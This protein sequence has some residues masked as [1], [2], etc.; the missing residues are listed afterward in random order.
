MRRIIN[1][2]SSRLPLWGLVFT[3]VAA[4]SWPAAAQQERFSTLILAPDPGEVVPQTTEMISL[5]FADPDR[6]LDVGSVRLLVDQIDRTAEATVNGD[7]LVWVPQIPLRQGVHSI[8]ITM[9][10]MDGSGLPAVSWSFISGAPPEGVSLEAL[11]VREEKRG[12]PSWALLQGNVTFEGMMTNVGGD[13][14]DLQREAPYTG[15]AW[16]NARGRLGGSWRYSANTHLNS[17]ESHIRQPINR[18]RFNLRSNWLTLTVG[19]V[20]PRIHELILWG[21]RVRGWSLDLRGGIVN[22]SVV[23]G[24]SRRAVAAQLYSDDP[25]RVFRRGTF[26]QD[27]FAIRP[28]FG[29]GR[30]LQ[31]GIT[32]MKARDDTTSIQF[33]RTEPDPADSSSST[34]LAVPD[35]KDNLV[36][37][38]DM[39]LKAFRGKLSLSYNN[40]FSLYANDISGG[41]LTKQELDDLMEE[42]GYDPIELPLGLEGPEDLADFFIINESMIPIDPR[43]MTNFA[44]QVRG[45]L[46]IGGHTIGARWRNVGGSYNT[47]G[48]YSLQ[49]DRSG[50]RVQDTFRLLDNR[51]GVTVGWEKYNDN[52]DDTKPAT[53][54]TSA[55]TLDLS[56]RTDMNSPGFA[57][58]Y[59][60]YGRYNDLETAAEG[61]VDEDTGTYS[62]GAFIPVNMIGGLN[63]RLSFNYTSVGREDAL[64]PLTGT[65]NTYYLIGLNNRLEGR[66]T[67]FSVMYG[68]NTSE[69][70]GY[71]AETTF[72]RLL[73]KGRHALTNSLAGTAD[74]TMTT[75]S[76]PESAGDLGLD[77]SKWEM[78]GGAEYYWAPTSFATLRAGFVTYTD[79]R[80]EGVDTS[81]L[82]V[83]LRITQVF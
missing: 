9:R 10:A 53:T 12:L 74:I 39:S 45:T 46:Q 17:Y 18:F 68:L 1:E 83:R 66:P 67:E 58:G 38:L 70:T 13:G 33:L 48:Y 41:P 47:L 20:N 61:G 34:V 49:K 16:L 72:N 82:V 37:G 22:V 27:L 7:V 77:Y 80:R 60:T 73:I 32:F 42:Q 64:N 6:V 71:D 26:A 40:A 25:T 65:N 57:L 50:L 44:Q 55:L 3:A 28:Y 15:K 75:A 54:G 14:A 62:A 11:G 5:S 43:G 76:S 36:I 30:G 69:L 79:S 78:T 31:F 4:H 35:P 52:L 29:S 51:L 2:I 81:Q 23:S 8:V 19:D 63:S 56:W 24:K 59:R 21:R